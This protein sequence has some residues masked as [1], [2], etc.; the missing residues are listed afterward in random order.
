MHWD[1]D[2]W[3]YR[4]EGGKHIVVYNSTAR[5]VLRIIK[6]EPGEFVSAEADRNEIERR[7]KFEKLVIGP[8]CADYGFKADSGT[9]VWLPKSFVSKL[10]KRIEKDRPI[11]RRNKVIPPGDRYAV[12]QLDF[13]N[14]INQPNVPNIALELKP[15]CGWIPEGRVACQ[16][17]LQQL[18]KIR[19]GKYESR[20]A[21]CPVDLFSA[22]LDR[23]RFALAQLIQNPQNNL[24][25]FIDGKLIYSMETMEELGSAVCA[26]HSS[27][28]LDEVCGLG[29]ALEI[30]LDQL[31]N[32]LGS[33]CQKKEEFCQAS[34]YEATEG[35]ETETVNLNGPLRGISHLQQLSG[36]SPNNVLDAFRRLS[37][38]QE[39]DLQEPDI[40][41][42]Q[43]ARKTQSGD[44]NDVDIVRRHLISAAAKDCSLIIVFNP[45]SIQNP[46]LNFRME[47]VD[48]DLKPTSKLTEHAQ[49]EITRNILEKSDSLFL[50]LKTV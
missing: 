17:C 8:I 33:R 22:R 23:K 45:P 34:T 27:G 4:A 16:F 38:A 37:K 26:K 19:R 41:W 11:A 48:V 12:L 32:C 9:L 47:I 35:D 40:T 28:Q 42:C 30:V 39:D 2:Q 14:S 36:Q 50:P 21:Y 3:S 13:C 7:L 18:E 1:P 44:L 43:S 24:R 15:K 5:K 6:A 10:S 46:I 25:F 29:G 20:S 31:C 49:K